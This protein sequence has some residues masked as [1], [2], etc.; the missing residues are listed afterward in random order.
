MRSYLRQIAIA[1]DQLLNALAWGKADETLSA[2]AHRM[3][4]KQQP[5]WGWSADAI[6]LLF[7]WQTDSNGKRNHCESSYLSEIERRHLPEH[8][9]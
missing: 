8:Y 2:R 5:V 7:F 1:I 3:R 9:W 6:D 4:I